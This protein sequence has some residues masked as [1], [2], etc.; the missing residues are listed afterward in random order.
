[1]TIIIPRRRGGTWE[2]V[3]VEPWCSEW[4]CRMRGGLVHHTIMILAAISLPLLRGAC[5]RPCTNNISKWLVLYQKLQFVPSPKKFRLL[6]PNQSLTGK[7]IPQ[8]YFTYRPVQIFK[9]MF[10]RFLF[11][12]IWSSA[13]DHALLDLLLNLV[14]LFISTRLKTTLVCWKW[15]VPQLYQFRRSISGGPALQYFY[16]IHRVRLPFC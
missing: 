8:K 11:C 15:F 7:S 12:R 13:Q 10:Q 1:M 6:G 2:G 9:I 4:I 5:S 3:P 14:V 16:M